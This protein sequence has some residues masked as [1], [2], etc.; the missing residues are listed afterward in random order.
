[1]LVDSS[2]V[3]LRAERSDEGDGRVYSIFAV[4]SDDDGNQT[5]LTCK[6]R[7]PR[8]H[9]KSALEGA[10][11]YCVGQDCGSVPSHDSHCEQDGGDDDYRH[12]KGNTLHGTL[13]RHSAEI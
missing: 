12:D 3:K 4:I 9:K 13:D 5:P 8:H 2:T 10:A 6:V 11:V 7:V 1:V